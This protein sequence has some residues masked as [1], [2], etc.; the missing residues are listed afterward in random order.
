MRSFICHFMQHQVNMTWLR[1]SAP[2]RSL[3]AP[4]S[5][6][7]SRISINSLLNPSGNPI[8]EVS[9]TFPEDLPQNPQDQIPEEAP[10]I[11]T[12][13]VPVPTRFFNRGS[14]QECSYNY[15]DSHTEGRYQ[16]SYHQPQS[17]PTLPSLFDEPSPTRSYSYSSQASLY[18]PPPSSCSSSYGSSCGMTRS[19]N[20]SFV[21]QH[22]QHPR[23]YP[24]AGVKGKT[25]RSQS[26]NSPPCLRRRERYSSFSSATSTAPSTAATSSSGG[27]GGSAGASSVSPERRRPPRPKYDEE[28]MYFIWYHRVDLGQEWKEVRESFNSQ[29][30]HRQRKGYQGI[31][32]KYYRLIKEKNCP[33]LREQHRKRSRSETSHTALKASPKEL[34]DSPMY[35]VLEWTNIRYPWMREE[36]L[37]R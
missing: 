18:Q 7:P 19:R 36:D 15:N 14:Q 21:H 27:G 5:S 8:T 37:K 26:V 3:M 9:G 16:P 20:S 6:S 13:P 2:V 28:E 10:V 11:S 25:Q 17:L 12:S 30:P 24:A 34:D 4:V 31:Q 35:G 22:Y 32:C 23:Q 33:T 29:F 1:P